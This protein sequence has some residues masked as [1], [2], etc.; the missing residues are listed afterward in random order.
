MKKS[1]LK[2][3]PMWL[4]ILL[5]HHRWTDTDGSKWYMVG[6]LWRRSRGSY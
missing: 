3:M 5:A 2:R 4:F 1:W 6:R